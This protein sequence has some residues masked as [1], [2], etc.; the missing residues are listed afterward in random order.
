MADALS[1]WRKRVCALSEYTKKTTQN[2]N[3]T[4]SQAKV[5]M[6]IGYV[7]HTI[8]TEYREFIIVYN[9]I[10]ACEWLY[11]DSKNSPSILVSP[12][13]HNN[14]LCVVRRVV[15]LVR[16]GLKYTGYYYNT[17][18]RPNDDYHEKST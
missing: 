7:V 10:T 18:H 17:H 9:T 8:A 15:F 12:D 4:K 6:W 1:K 2:L 13:S 14:K 5:N 11:M 3:Q 16:D